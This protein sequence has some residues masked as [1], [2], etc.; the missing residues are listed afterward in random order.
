MFAG[1]AA[2]KKASGSRAGSTAVVEA[3]HSFSLIVCT[4]LGDAQAN[5]CMEPAAAQAELSASDALSALQHRALQQ[6]SPSQPAASNQTGTRK[7]CMSR[8][9]YFVA[10]GT[11]ATEPKSACCGLPDR[12]M[13]ALYVDSL[14]L[15]HDSALVSLLQSLRQVICRTCMYI[16]LDLMHNRAPIRLL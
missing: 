9:S 12:Y 10:Q 14:A 8:F 1:S 13:Q 2:S 16:L 3:V 6:Q 4:T 7:H 15:L 5:A 11:A